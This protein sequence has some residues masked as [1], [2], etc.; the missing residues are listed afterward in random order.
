M[1]SEWPG[2]A[3]TVH[4]PGVNL[5]SMNLTGVTPILYASDFARSMDYFVD[6]LGFRKLW[7]WGT[8]PTFGAVGRG[9]IELFLC[10]GSQGQPG[11]WLSIFLDDV[12]ELHADL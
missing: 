10:F 7:D 8:P 9:H 11:T 4:G 12:D 1:T 2:R 5:P 3:Q 6:K